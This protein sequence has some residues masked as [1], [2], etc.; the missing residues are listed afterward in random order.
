MLN[1]LSQLMIIINNN[2]VNRKV[3]APGPLEVNL[4]KL[5][6]CKNYN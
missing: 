4:G 1:E 2:K 6:T 3:F 5:H